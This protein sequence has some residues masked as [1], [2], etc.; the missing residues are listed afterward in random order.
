[1]MQFTRFVMQVPDLS[2]AGDFYFNVLS[3]ARSELETAETKDARTIPWD[4]PWYYSEGEDGPPIHGGIWGAEMELALVTPERN[5]TR[6]KLRYPIDPARSTV[7]YPVV[8]AV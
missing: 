7:R 8:V 2:A 4:E 1:M 6:P 3:V 5:H